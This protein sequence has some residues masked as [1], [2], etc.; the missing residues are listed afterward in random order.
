MDILGDE[1]CATR[2]RLC[3]TSTLVTAQE[4]SDP[5]PVETKGNCVDN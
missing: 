5:I 4:L 1:H 3:T 2:S